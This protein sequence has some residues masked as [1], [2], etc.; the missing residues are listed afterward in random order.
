MGDLLRFFSVLAT[1]V[2]LGFA[3]YYIGYL[4]FPNLSN[5]VARIAAATIGFLVGM[6]CVSWFHSR[7]VGR[8]DRQI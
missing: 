1:G 7:P 5:P 3:G 4:A 2:I 8:T 6:L